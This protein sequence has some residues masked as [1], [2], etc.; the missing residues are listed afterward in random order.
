MP[1]AKRNKDRAKVDELI[2]KYSKLSTDELRQALVK[3]A[4]YLYKK[5]ET[6]IRHV[7]EGRERNAVDEKVGDWMPNKSLDRSRER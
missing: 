3:G 2:A 4:P 5:A 7:I 6:A 1:T